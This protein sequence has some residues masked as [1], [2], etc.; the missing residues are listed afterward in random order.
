MVYVLNNHGTPLM[1]TTRLGKVR[2]LLKSGRAVIISHCPFTIQLTYE[3]KNFT[4]E[5]ALGVDAGSTYIGLS[6]TTKS[7]VLFEATI[8]LRKDIMAKLNER[9]E[10]RHTRRLKHLRHRQPRYLNR[11]RLH[12]Q[13][14]LPPSIQAKLAVHCY[15]IKRVLHM[16]PVTSVNI[17]GAQFDM[18]KLKQTSLFPNTNEI[19][20][21]LK[22]H[23]A[24][25]YV[26]ARDNYT[27]KI[28]KGK[29]K[30]N[31]LHVHHIISRITGSNSPD[32]LVT[33]CKDCH[34]KLH[35][36]EAK[37]PNSINM[38]PRF[39]EASFMTVARHFLIEQVTD[40]LANSIPVHETYGYITKYIREINNM[41]K[42]HTI[43][44]RC[45]SGNPLACAPTTT[46]Y[47]KKLRC[48]NRKLHKVNTIKGGI[49][50]INQ[51]PKEVHGFRLM[52]CVLYNGHLAFISGRRAEGYFT[53]KTIDGQTVHN[54]AKFN[55]ITLVRHSNSYAIAEQLGTPLM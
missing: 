37:L 49:R 25:E 4:K 55:K 5:I 24:R 6:A 41:P 29:S 20:T 1:P 17:E 12:N 27:C 53:L 34:A 40:M 52:D 51:C 28:C 15:W 9:K 48:N 8:E 39:R 23:N 10:L 2:H 13:Y 14:H 32:N 36:G 18:S 11:K 31:N 30:C 26:L 54:S 43:D 33:L 46:Y 42:S 19:E 44:A 50:K 38:I 7:Q 3:S 21:A 16:L 22:Y 47:I 45:I 35:R